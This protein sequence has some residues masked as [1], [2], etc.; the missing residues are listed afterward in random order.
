[1]LDLIQANM[2]VEKILL[3][4]IQQAFEKVFDIKISVKKIDI[5][6]TSK[7]HVGDYSFMV[8]PYLKYTKISPEVTAKAIG[9][10]LAEQCSRVKQIHIVN[11]YVNILLT[12]DYWLNFLLEVAKLERYGFNKPGSKKETQ[13]LEYS[14]PNTN[15][16]LHLGHIRNNLIG[17][18]VS[19]IL[20][21]AGY[22]VIKLNLINDRGIHICKSM[23][24]WQ[25][26]GENQTPESSGIKG[27]HF[28]GKFY[29]M[30]D[31]A[32]KAEIK[33]LMQSGI[34]EDEAKQSAPL[35]L[36]AQKMLKEWELN[37]PAVISL[38]KKMNDWVYEGFNETYGKMG[39]CFDNF[40]YESETYLLGKQVVK[41]ALNNEYIYQK[42]DGSIW[43]N[44]ESHALDQKLLLR[45]DDTSV[46][47][48][49]DI[50]TA[51]LR[52]KNYDACKAIY[53]VADEQNY[54]FQVL[55]SL[56]SILGYKGNESL[57]HLSYGMVELP[58]GRMKS[59]EGTVVDAD[60]LMENMVMQAK[61]L[62]LDHERIENSNNISSEVSTL[63]LES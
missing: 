28:V 34:D 7:D 31:K 32:Y 59:R 60:D 4:H 44:L 24:A 13:L 5:I 36:E 63:H 55:K 49:Q 33:E 19:E 10:F 52:F 62:I 16:P 18:S 43:V 50:G 22:D 21:A 6:T 41:E 61:N 51:L 17:H 27:D 3:K 39:V 37:D 53:V 9:E 8:H 15:K 38:W 58:N 54:H 1:M 40:E 23:L 48:T 29:V 30:F 47:I 46:Y 12:D 57:K 14:S 11:G 20:K 35:I 26:W 2:G 25:K 45:G 56:L 42:E